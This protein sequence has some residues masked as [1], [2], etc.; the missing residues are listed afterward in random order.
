MN[1]TYRENKG[2]KYVSGLNPARKF[3]VSKE[4][5]LSFHWCIEYK[6]SN[7][8]RK[9]KLCVNTKHT[10]KLFGCTAQ[11]LTGRE[12]EKTKTHTRHTFFLIRLSKTMRNHTTP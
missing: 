8:A 7:L 6:E 9:G 10:T 4:K 1:S 5:N 3:K 2:V 11:P 12:R